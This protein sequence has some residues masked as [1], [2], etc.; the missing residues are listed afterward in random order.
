MGIVNPSEY[1]QLWNVLY[2]RG[3]GNLPGEEYC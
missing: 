3:A 1:T 2:C